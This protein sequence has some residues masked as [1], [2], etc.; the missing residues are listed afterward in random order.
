MMMGSVCQGIV[1]RRLAQTSCFDGRVECSGGGW[2]DGRLWYHARGG[3]GY[4]RRL[5]C[6]RRGACGG[7]VGERVVA[8]GSK[9][10]CEVGVQGGGGRY[11]EVASGEGSLSQLGGNAAAQ[12]D[13]NEL[14]NGLC[15]L[16][17]APIIEIG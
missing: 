3:C 1:P 4:G 15:V 12:G 14:F 6:G 7:S 13:A 17:D 10:G 8:R 9:R 16:G 5:A 11:L 2:G